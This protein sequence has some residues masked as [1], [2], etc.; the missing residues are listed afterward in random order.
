VALGLPIGTSNYHSLQLQVRKDFSHGLNLLASY[1]FA[2]AIDTSSVLLSCAFGG[3]APAQNP[4]NINGDRGLAN[5][6]QRKRLVLSFIY[7][8]P[9]LSQALGTENQVVKKAFD[10]WEVGAIASFGDGFPFTVVSGRDNSLTAYGNDRPNLVGQP[11]LDTGRPRAELL[12][13]YFD[14]SAFVANP[15][16]TFGNVG[17]NTLIGPG[18]I[19]IDFSLFKNIP[20]SERYGRIQL[21]LE[22]FNAPNRPNFGSP[23]ASL[24]APANMGRILSARDGRIL[25]LGGKYIF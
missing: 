17:R 11:N 19:S 4:E 24:A 9:S 15:A 7:D 23:G 14:P 21:R 5:F 25:Q 13:R 8:T 20:I 2:K 1:T 10:D 6:D 3:S 18:S 12:N 22:L 16:G